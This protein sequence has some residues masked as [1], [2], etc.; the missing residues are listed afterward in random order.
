MSG[1]N[2]GTQGDIPSVLDDAPKVRDQQQLS[3]FALAAR[4]APSKPGHDHVAAADSISRAQWEA[5]EAAES[6]LGGQGF[7]EEQWEALE[8]AAEVAPGSVQP[9]DDPVSEDM[10]AQL[11]RFYA[12]VRPGKV[13][14]AHSVVAALGGTREGLNAHLRSRYDLDLDASDGELSYRMALRAQLEELYAAAG[15]AGA[16]ARAWS[17]A[18][19]FSSPKD[20]AELDRLFER[21]YG[22]GIPATDL[23][24]LRFQYCDGQDLA[25]G[26][27]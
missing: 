23:V 27:N 17:V 8:S 24:R 12:A 20:L 2:E 9:E 25:V 5:L 18:A 7:T 11:T 3:A 4:S 6:N 21:K 26:Q 16:A 22:R 19:R 1:E 14:Q 10:L 15:E 13:A